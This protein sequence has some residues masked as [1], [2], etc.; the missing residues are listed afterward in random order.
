MRILSYIT[1]S[2]SFF[3]M[4][5]CASE[6]EKRLTEV[7]ESAGS[8]RVELEK[9]LAHYKSNPQKLAAA[10]FLIENMTGNFFITPEVEEVCEP[11]YQLYDS[12]NGIYPGHM[13]AAKGKK[14]DSL[15]K[16]FNVRPLPR[17]I[18]WDAEQITSEFL[19]T[20]ID[21]S[22]EAWQGNVYSKEVPFQEFLEY[23]LPYRRENRLL[24]EDSRTE[25]YQKHR[26]RF[27]KT[28]GRDF[29]DETDSLLY[30]YRAISH[31]QNYGERI[32]IYSC[33]TLQR[34]QKGLCSQRCWFNSTLLSAVG[35]PVA[36]DMVPAWGNR[37]NSHTWNVLILHGQSYAFE[38][39]WDDDRWKYK[40]IYNN[41]DSDKKWG[42]FRLPKV[43]RLT[44]SN[45]VEGPIADE[46]ME[47]KDIPPLF[48]Q[49][50][51]K[52]VSEE[53]FDTQDV[54]LT[55]ADVP[56]DTYYA[57]LCVFGYQDWH[58]VQWGRIEGNKVC[59]KGMGRDIVYLPVY[60]ANG[61][62]RYAGNPFFLTS[63]GKVEPLIP[64]RETE[65]VVVRDVLG[66]AVHL[67]NREYTTCMNGTKLFTL[68]GN[69]TGELLCAVAD[70]VFMEPTWFKAYP[71][72]P[73]R[74]IRLELPSDSIA[75]SD[76]S[77]YSERNKIEG[78]K[79]LT[80]LNSFI[81]TDKPEWLVD[82]YSATSYRG[83]TPN[84][85]IDIDLGKEYK[86]TALRM[87]SYIKSTL[88]AKSIFELF[89]WDN[90]WKTLGK[91]QGNNNFLIF[92]GVPRS[93]LLMLKNCSWPGASSERIFFYKGGDVIGA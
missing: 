48:R 72:S 23:V 15:W 68:L 24:L 56:A 77:F 93:S 4:I 21:R 81:Q 79:I 82:R 18:Y 67:D 50:K 26:D 53:Y 8:N 89:Y 16:A 36:T 83:K 19:I 34:L 71:A 27:Y 35:M 28:K 64:S 44:Y 31:S 60:C 7:L 75:L 66:S 92:E 88:Y 29:I 32:P 20:E 61:G 59:F 51:K 43:Y 91:Q 6:K 80:P 85:Y 78:V 62:M 10:Q 70:T 1:L 5:S 33:R 46:R 49:F 9:V 55:L 87:S 13:T 38:P 73:C 37:N 25:Y 2:L 39:Y 41:K 40:T 63:E 90:G 17:K 22:F 45:H 3:L 42:K 11:F 57:Y 58:P 54:T 86:V 12:I 76:L 69:H 65:R 30:L 14:I 52:D 84:K 47:L 74:Y